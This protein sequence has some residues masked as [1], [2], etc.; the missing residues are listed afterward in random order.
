MPGGWRRSRPPCAGGGIRR[1]A[2]GPAGVL[3]A[4]VVRVA[5]LTGWSGLAVI[6]F[7]DKPRMGIAFG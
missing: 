2:A 4:V 1:Q 5:I 6:G 3:S 7:P